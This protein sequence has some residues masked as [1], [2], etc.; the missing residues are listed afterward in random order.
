MIAPSPLAPLSA[1][2]TEVPAALVFVADRDSEGVIR[3]CLAGIGVA[4]N[5]VNGDI[6]AAITSLARADSPRLLIVDISDVPDP[7]SR[8][9]ALAEVCEPS[10]GVIV[11]GEVNDIRLYRSLRDAGV[12]EYFFKPLVTSMVTRVCNEVLTGISDQ[13]GVRLGKLVILMSVRGGSGATTIGAVLAWQLAEA[14]Q[15]RTLLI[16]L[17]MHFGDLALQL[18]VRPNEAL[19]EALQHPERIDDLFLERGVIEVT[20]RLGLLASLEAC[21]DVSLIDEDA[22]L[23]LLTM[24]LRRYRYVL[25]DLPAELA[26]RLP[27]M[28]HLPATCLLVSDGSLVAARD[29]ARWRSKLGPDTLERATLHVLNKADPHT[30][31]P[32]HEFGIAAGQAPNIIIPYDRE[33]AT[34]ATLGLQH[35]HDRASLQHGIAPVL[36]LLTGEHV[37]THTSLLSRMFH[38]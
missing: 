8:V 12:A 26:P 32:P 34:A 11:V 10:T 25:L 4:T 37:A 16:D 28:L 36:R 24:L 19:C 22:V 17:D 14:L 27:R 23:A 33:V 31:L 38:R 5:F 29:V 30:G 20:P 21:D 6:E 35:V 15:R 7:V 13:R 9:R 2:S 18:D 3:Q 1:A